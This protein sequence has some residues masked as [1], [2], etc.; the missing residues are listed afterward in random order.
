MS[1]RTIVTVELNDPT[2]TVELN[3][4]TKHRRVAAR[5]RIMNSASPSE[6]RERIDEKRERIDDWDRRRV[7][8]ALDV[9]DNHLKGASPGVVKAVAARLEHVAVITSHVVHPALAN[10][11]DKIEYSQE[12]YKCFKWTAEMYIMRMNASSDVKSQYETMFEAF[13]DPV[14]MASTLTELMQKFAYF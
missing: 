4:P 12:E 10:A 8:R 11:L 13:I 5:K 3:E 6:K 9:L 2:V 1:D 7:R 14:V